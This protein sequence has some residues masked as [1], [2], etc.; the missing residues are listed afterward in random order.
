M[1]GGSTGGGGATGGGGLG[2]GGDGGG[3]TC[4]GVDGGG[5]GGGGGES[6]GGGGCCGAPAGAA[7]GWAGGG[8]GDGSGDGGGC[9]GAAGGLQVSELECGAAQAGHAA[10]M[11][12]LHWR[13]ALASLGIAF[14]IIEPHASFT[15]WQTLRH[16]GISIP[17]AQPFVMSVQTN[18]RSALEQLLGSIQNG[19]GSIASSTV[20][21]RHA[22]VDALA[23]T[24]KYGCDEHEEIVGREQPASL[25]AGMAESGRSRC[26]GSRDLLLR[27]RRVAL[28]PPP[29]GLPKPHSRPR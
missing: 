8:G 3:G 21:C 28:P 24:T 22:A 29:R 11:Y 18:L 17:S 14:K 6:G 25:H 19:I 15:A 4:G 23:G 13:R 27:V 7:G 2:G 20:L 10:S 5:A 26:V 9:G 12:W 1:G 16:I